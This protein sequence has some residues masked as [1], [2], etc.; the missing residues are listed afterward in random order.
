MI[1]LAMIDLMARRC[2]GEST[3]TWRGTLNPGQ[4]DLT[5]PNALSALAIGQ[6]AVA[7]VAVD[8]DCGAG[9]GRRAGDPGQ[10]GTLRVRLRHGSG[11]E[12]PP[13]PVPVLGQPGVEECG[14][15]CVRADGGA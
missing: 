9:H 5:G 10:R 2:T 11:L 8:S 4:A 6:G 7:G 15:R 14:V 3:P 1:H 12:G 13:G